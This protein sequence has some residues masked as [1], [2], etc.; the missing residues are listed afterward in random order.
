[1]AKQIEN[2]QAGVRTTPGGLLCEFYNGSVAEAVIPA[3]AVDDGSEV[4]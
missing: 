4:I 3:K 1:V 2:R